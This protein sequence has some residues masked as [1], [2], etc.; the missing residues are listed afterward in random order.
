MIKICQLKITPMK[1][2]KVEPFLIDWLHRT[3]PKNFPEKALESLRSAPNSDEQVV[4]FAGRVCYMSFPSPRPGGNYEYIKHIKTVG[5]G[6][7]LEHATC[8]LLFEGVS[9]TLTHELVRHRAGWSYSQLSQRYVDE[10]VA[11]YVCPDI[12]LQDEELLDIWLDAV[13]HAHKAYVKLSEKLTEKMFGMEGTVTE[14]RK[15]ARQ[16]ARSVLPN[17]CETK[18]TVTTN[19]RALRHFIEQRGSIHAEPEIRKLAVELWKILA[20]KW[21]N[22][23]GDYTLADSGTLSTPYPKV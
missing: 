19:A 14:L 6:S 23:F 20:V 4:E 11:E 13:E 2:G 21:P 16:A 7:V 3:Y 8:T 1:F 10:S 17:A 5:H 9:R 15:A 12:I 22:L 18:I